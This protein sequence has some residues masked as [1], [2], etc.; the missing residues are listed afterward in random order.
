VGLVRTSQDPTARPAESRCRSFGGVEGFANIVGDAAAVVD[1]VAVG[2]R[3][4]LDGSDVCSHLSALGATAVRSPEGPSSFN[5]RVI[6]LRTALL[7]LL[8]RLISYVPPSR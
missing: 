8:L 4:F 1:L 3:P 2:A 6:A 7:Y 5:A